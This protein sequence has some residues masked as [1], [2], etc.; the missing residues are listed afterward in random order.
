[1]LIRVLQTERK[2]ERKYTSARKFSKKTSKEK[3]KT[4]KKMN[5]TT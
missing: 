5:S 3:I 1:M 2:K 4:K